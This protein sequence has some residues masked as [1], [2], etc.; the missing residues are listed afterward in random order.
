Q[1]QDEVYLAE[2]CAERVTPLLVTDVELTDR[3]VW[4]TWNAV[5]G[6]RDTNDG[7]R[8]PP[9]AGVVAWVREHPRSRI[10]YI[11]FGDSPAAFANAGFRRLLANALH[12]VSERG[13]D[14]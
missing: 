4:S 9:S 14:R 7:W 13:A 6:R 10:V 5:L 1:I 11:Q 12:W 8:H 2:V 3:T